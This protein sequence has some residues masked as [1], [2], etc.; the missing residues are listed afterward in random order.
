MSD[1]DVKENLEV[2]V[3][4]SKGAWDLDADELLLSTL[5]ALQERFLDRLNEVRKDVDGLSEDVRKAT[6]EF[7][8]TVNDFIQLSQNQFVENRCAMEDDA[9]SDESKSDAESELDE[10]ERAKLVY[11]DAVQTCVTALEQRSIPLFESDDE[12]DDDASEGS[13]EDA[14]EEDVPNAR[15]HYRRRPLLA[16]IGSYEFLSDPHCGLGG[17]PYMQ[18]SSDDASSDS[19]AEPITFSRATPQANV[20]VQPVHPP[21]QISAPLQSPVPSAAPYQAPVAVSVPGLRDRV[22]RFYEVYNPSKLSDVDTI[23]T[24]FA[25]REDKLIPALVKRYGPEPGTGEARAPVAKKAFGA[26]GS[27]SDADAAPRAPAPKKAPPKKISKPLVSDSDSDSDAA[28][29]RPAPPA[30]KAPPK[31]AI[32]TDSDSDSDAAPKPAP[33]K[34]IPLPPRKMPVPK[35]LAS[36]SDSDAPA[37]VA[38]RPMAVRPKVKPSKT[39]IYSDSD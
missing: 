36:D 2:L 35:A 15:D 16:L 12:S 6:S 13:G 21:Q 28:P 30:K 17:D 1:I 32:A 11:T 4:A 8:N 7:Q 39:A 37:L 14:S 19:E 38:K 27:D 29:S 5:S 22:L 10:Q 23:L 31:K 3:D 26:D 24:T 18:E 20:Y 33:K 9:K 25:G 34:S